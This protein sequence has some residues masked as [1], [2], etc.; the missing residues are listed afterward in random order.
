MR[1]LMKFN[2]WKR[3]CEGRSMGQFVFCTD[4]QEWNRIESP[5]KLSLAFSSMLVMSNPNR[6]CFRG[7]GNTMCLERVKY[8]LVDTER[9]P[10]GTIFVIVCG[11]SIRG[12]DDI[13]YTLIAS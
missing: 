7:F 13:S 2:E 11:D 5:L 10:L 3:Y 9:T 12:E 6:I 8:I 1:S 4:N